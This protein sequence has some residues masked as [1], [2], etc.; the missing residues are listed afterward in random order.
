MPTNFPNGL[1]SYGIPLIGSGSQLPITNGNYYYVSSVTGSSGNTGT[2]I[3]S[4]K[5]TLQQAINLCTAANNDVVVLLPGHAETV[6][7]TSV[8]LNKSTVQI[9]ALGTGSTRATFTFDTAAATITVS[10]TNVSIVNCRF[11]ANFANVA[12]AFTLTTAVSCKIRDNEFVDTSS[13]LNFLCCVTTGATDNSADGLEFTGNYVYSL[14]ATDGAVVS[15]HSNTLRLNVSNNIVDKAA[16]NDAGHL[17]TLSSKI[18]GGVRIIGNILTVVG[19]SGAAVGVMFT[20]SGTTS[21]GICAYNLV[22]SLDTTGALIATAGTGISF[23]ENYM[24]GAVDKSGVIYPAT[25]N[26]A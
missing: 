24:T 3:S 7:A 20:G 14:P 2:T 4:P 9:I 18:V 15:I 10:A 1:A 13:I 21:S 11:V 22:S 25:D 26:P 16:T 6:T 8:A 19:S 5:A 17:I 12:S 23:L